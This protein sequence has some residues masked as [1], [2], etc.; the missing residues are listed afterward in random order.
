MTFSVGN[1]VMLKD[2]NNYSCTYINKLNL[3]KVKEVVDNGYILNNI[4]E[5]VAYTDV[6]P[7]PID[8][9][10]DSKIYYYY[11]VAANTYL[12]EE[13]EAKAKPMTQDM[14]Y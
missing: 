14:R 9:I 12:T 3:Y 7:V 5:I 13:A 11:I 10:H 8:R 1:I 2:P 6:L 4:N